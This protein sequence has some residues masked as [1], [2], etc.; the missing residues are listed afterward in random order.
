MPEEIREGEYADIMPD[1]SDEEYHTLKASIRQ[2]GFD[3]T[4]PIIVDE[5][6]QVV[7]G[8][9]RFR[10]C[11]ELDVEPVIHTVENPTVEQAY[12]VNLARRDLSVGIKNQLVA[13]YLENEYEGERTQGEI[14]AELGV[15]QSTVSRAMDKADLERIS[16][17]N[18]LSN[19]EKRQQAKTYLDANPD[20]T[21]REVAENIE[22]D[23][24]HT[25]VGNWRNK[26]QD[27][28]EGSSGEDT[29]PE[30]DDDDPDGNKVA[31]NTETD[32]PREREDTGCADCRRKDERITELEGM[33]EEREA[34]LRDLIQA[35]D[36]KD[37]EAVQGAT[38]RAKRLVG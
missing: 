8:H 4:I 25:S 33:I 16:R 9:H 36:N 27:A 37:A 30:Q 28:E 35:V 29:E 7:D 24:S 1:M 10:A 26:W 34:V 32:D 18:I 38:E 21:N 15:A 5:D 20:A 2:N 13:R 31:A 17:V 22:A 11:R 12:R 19:E 6:G 23:T 14:G 3:E